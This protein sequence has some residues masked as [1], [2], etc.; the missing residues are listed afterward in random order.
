MNIM[1]DPC[2]GKPLGLP[3][4]Q[5]NEKRL[6]KILGAIADPVRL[7][8]VSVISARGSLC[9]CDLEEPIKRSQPT[10]SHHTKVLAEADIIR[11]EKKGK[12]VWW[13]INVETISFLQDSLKELLHYDEI[14]GI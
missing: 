9:S 6:A 4:E 13:H 2:N 11:A 3:L 7:N 1:T 8:I 5:E 10:I 14:K 12:W